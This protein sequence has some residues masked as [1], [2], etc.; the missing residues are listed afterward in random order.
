MARDGNPRLVETWACADLVM[1]LVALPSLRLGRLSNGAPVAT[2]GRERRYLLVQY[3][4]HYYYSTCSWSRIRTGWVCH[5]Q[6]VP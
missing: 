1:K 6:N 3:S 5:I 4:R 2:V